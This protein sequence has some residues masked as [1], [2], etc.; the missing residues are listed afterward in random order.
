MQWLKSVWFENICKCSFW[1]IQII[2]VKSIGKCGSIVFYSFL[3]F[4]KSDS[5]KSLFEKVG[6]F[7]IT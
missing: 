5:N 3:Y 2:V 1:S 6:I 4:S 7:Q